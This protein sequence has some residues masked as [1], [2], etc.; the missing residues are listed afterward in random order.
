[1]LIA[2]RQF[3][4]RIS[5]G[6]CIFCCF[7]VACVFLLVTKPK[8]KLNIKYCRCLSLQSVTTTLTR[9][10]QSYREYIQQNSDKQKKKKHSQHTHSRTHHEEYVNKCATTMKQCPVTRWINIWFYF[11]FLYAYMHFTSTTTTT[12]ATRTEIILCLTMHFS[13]FTKCTFQHTK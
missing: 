2:L 4:N 1:M 13:A 3:Q 12:T 5:S 8:I 9:C 11:V 7:A 6:F 10:M